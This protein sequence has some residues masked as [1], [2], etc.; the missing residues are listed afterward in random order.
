VTNYYSLYLAQQLGNRKF[1]IKNSKEHFCSCKDTLLWNLTA[2]LKIGGSGQSA[3]TSPGP[4]AKGGVEGGAFDQLDNNGRVS[5]ST[6]REPVLDLSGKIV[7]PQSFNTVNDEVL[8]VIDTGIDTTL[9]DWNVYGPLLTSNGGSAINVMPDVDSTKYQDGEEVRHGSAVTAIALRAFYEQC[10]STKMLPRIMAVKALDDHGYGSTF[11]ISCGLSYAMRHKATL[12]NA[13]LGYWGKQD[14]VLSYYLERCKQQN[15]P[16]I[17][18]AGNDTL[19]HEGPLCF[20]SVRL[21]TLLSANPNYMFYPACLSTDSRY[22]VI[23]VTGMSSSLKPCRFQFYSP[24]FV[25]IGVVTQ[26][27]LPGF[28]SVSTFPADICCGFRLPFINNSYALDGSSF[29]TPVISGQI[30]YKMVGVPHNQPNSFWLGKLSTSTMPV[31]AQ[32]TKNGK[33]IVVN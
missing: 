27:P 20:D 1:R 9:F 32:Y 23:T 26:D 3:P 11:S 21:N 18:A 5:K 24:T 29:A 22:S 7:F 12:I 6:M 14:S 2:D 4:V 13:S 31:G 30:L 17:A 33:Y 28:N 15:I 25:D 8:A 10:G 16:V 19:R